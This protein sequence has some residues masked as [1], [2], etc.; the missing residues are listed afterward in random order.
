MPREFLPG[1]FYTFDR[2]APMREIGKRITRNQALFR[3]RGSKRKAAGE[4]EGTGDKK[5]KAPAAPKK[6]VYTPRSSDAARLA[7]DVHPGKADWEGSHKPSISKHGEKD[8]D[9]DL[10]GNRRFPHF[11]PGGDHDY[12]HVFYGERGYRVDEKRG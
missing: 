6:D 7:K 12:G 4:R 8:W 3:L 10:P 1:E 5:G 11:H 9:Y 2:K